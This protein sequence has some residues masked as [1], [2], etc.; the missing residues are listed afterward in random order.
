VASSSGN[1]KL[2]LCAPGL[3]G[4]VLWLVA[5][6]IATLSGLFLSLVALFF[7]WALW[8]LWALSLFF[9]WLSGLF[10]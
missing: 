4:L 7:L 1:S 5:L 8:V 9:V 6:S 10:L 2:F 3:S